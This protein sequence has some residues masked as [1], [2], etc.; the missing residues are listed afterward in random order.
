M[1]VEARPLWNPVADPETLVQTEPG[2]WK[3]DPATH[4]AGPWLIIGWSGNW[5]R[6]RPLLWVVRD[7][8]SV[9][10]AQTT[11]LQAITIQ[12]VTRIAD[13]DT[14]RIAFER[15]FQHLAETPSDP[16]WDQFDR[17][18][19]SYRGL[20]AITLDL[21]RLLAANAEAATLALLRSTDSQFELLWSLLENMP[22]SW[23]LVTIHTWTIAAKRYVAALG[24]DSPEIFDLL[25]NHVI[26]VVRDKIPAR[27][28]G[29]EVIGAWIAHDVLGG[30]EEARKALRLLAHAS[31]RTLFSQAIAEAE[32][33]LTQ[34][35]ASDRWPQG[36]H[37]DELERA[38]HTPAVMRG[39]W[40]RAPEGTEFREPVMNAPIA[41]ALACACNVELG[42]NHVYNVRRLREFDTEWFDTVYENILKIAV[43]MLMEHDVERLA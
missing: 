24:A 12:D 8:L 20:P 32:E 23:R 22:F 42:K 36:Y 33:R 3:F 28:R 7:S 6:L 30:N 11:N 9:D 14:R 31:A 17:F 40:R 35:H 21:V 26:T 34:V 5:C 25:K 13:R 10:L 19:E 38:V 2:V 15:L 39:L 29:A 18:I 4:L 16:E 27:I 37:V 43:G 1:R 41:A